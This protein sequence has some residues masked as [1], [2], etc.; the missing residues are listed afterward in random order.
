MDDKWQRRLAA[1]RLG[2]GLQLLASAGDRETFFIEQSF[3]P[4]DILNIPLAVQALARTAL[5][6]RKQ[7]EFRLPET[8]D[9]GRQIAKSGHFA[10]PEV[11]FVRNDNVTRAA[12]LRA[13]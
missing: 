8:Q 11:K 10:D 9:V 6:G 1:R 13:T 12:V 7:W 3:Y 2:F 4:Y 5:L